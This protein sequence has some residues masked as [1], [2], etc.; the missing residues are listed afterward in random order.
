MP[1]V[2]DA[3]DEAALDYDAMACDPLLADTAAFCEKYGFTP[4]QSANTIIVVGKAEPKVY[5]CCVVLANTRLDVNKKV[6][7]LLGI[8]KASF[9]SM[10]ETIALSNMEIGGVV[11]VGV[12]GMPVY[13][14]AAVMQ[15]P[16]VVM[17]GGNRSSKLLLNPQEL[18][19]L[20]RAEVVEDLAKPKEL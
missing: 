18:L 5:A 4:E 15:Q 3:A 9:A 8:R 12:Q 1:L 16:Q 13:I 7:Q 19:K 6:C 10:D 2:K 11:A 14:D 20:P 17:G